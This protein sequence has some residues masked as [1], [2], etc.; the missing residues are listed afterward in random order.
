MDNLDK[1]K[2][3]DLKSIKNGGGGMNLVSNA[4]NILNDMKDLANYNAGS[5]EQRINDLKNQNRSFVRREQLPFDGD[6]A[7]ANKPGRVD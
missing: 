5:A 3:G 2:S 6:E 7:Y 4:K 1:I